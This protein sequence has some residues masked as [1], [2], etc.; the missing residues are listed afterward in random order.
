MKTPPRTGGRMIEDRNAGGKK[1]Y[2]LVSIDLEVE[3]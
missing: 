1:G 2:A 3:Q